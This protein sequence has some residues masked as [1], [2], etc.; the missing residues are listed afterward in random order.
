MVTVCL[1]ESQSMIVPIILFS[2][3]ARTKWD[4]VNRFFIIITRSSLVF[5]YNLF[6]YDRIRFLELYISTYLLFL[7]IIFTKVGHI[8]ME[9]SI[10]IY[11]RMCDQVWFWL[12]SSNITHSYAILN[13]KNTTFLQ[14]VIFFFVVYQGRRQKCFKN[15]FCYREQ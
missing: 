12:H 8:K 14:F 2:K 4:L 7:F 3:V 6:I 1:T 5:K 9:F 13:G 15:I 10:Q 11:S